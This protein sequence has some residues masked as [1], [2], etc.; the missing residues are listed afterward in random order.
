VRSA[1]A[2]AFSLWIPAESVW[3]FAIWPPAI[4]PAEIREALVQRFNF[5][6]PERFQVD[7]WFHDGKPMGAPALSPALLFLALG[8]FN[9][10]WRFPG[11]NSAINPSI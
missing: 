8:G 9:F 6:T 3:A 10:C 11:V 1:I 4:V 5:D 7:G 2:V